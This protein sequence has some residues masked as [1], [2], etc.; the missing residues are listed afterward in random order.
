MQNHYFCAFINYYQQRYY[1]NKN[2]RIKCAQNI[3]PKWNLQ[4]FYCN[5]CNTFFLHLSR[6]LRCHTVGAA[7]YFFY[8]IT[9]FVLFDVQA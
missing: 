2:I 1:D 7:N 5:D 6:I 3:P 9:I 8:E 4:H